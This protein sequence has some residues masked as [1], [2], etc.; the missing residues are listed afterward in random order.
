[1]L[2]AAASARSMAGQ[3][4]TALTTKRFAISTASFKALGFR[5]QAELSEPVFEV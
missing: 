4:A 1:M 2:S 5:E 3:P